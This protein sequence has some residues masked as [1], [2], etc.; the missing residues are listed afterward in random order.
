MMPDGMPLPGP[1]VDPQGTAITVANQ[2]VNFGWEYVWHCHILSHE[3]MDMMRPQ[4]V[5]LPPKAPSGLRVDVTSVAKNGKSG[6]LRVNWS[7]NSIADTAY[8]VQ[9]DTGSG[10]VDLATIQVPLDQPNTMGPM[11]YDDTTWNPQ[12]PLPQYQVVAQNAVGYFGAG[13]T[14]PTVT[15]ESVS[16]AASP[17]APSQ[18]AIVTASAA[19]Q[20]SKER[21]TVTW[22]AVPGATGYIVQWS[23]DSFATIAGSGAVGNVTTFTTGNIARQ[24]WDF[25]LIATNPIGQSPP[26]AVF[27]VP[28]A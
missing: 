22:S 16:A 8:L 26:S 25:R 1:L 14:F 17:T 18:P 7:D 27:T 19:R 6:T 24:V 13:G 3:E 9:R 5:A 21:V 4:A 15:A 10:F 23:S 28:S 2:L 12:G 20:G 11:S